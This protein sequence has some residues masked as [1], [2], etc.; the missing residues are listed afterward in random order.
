MSH[1]LRACETVKEY[2]L[3]LKRSAF[4]GKKGENKQDARKEIPLKQLK[5]TSCIPSSGKHP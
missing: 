2:I 1:K 3:K 5:H 4:E